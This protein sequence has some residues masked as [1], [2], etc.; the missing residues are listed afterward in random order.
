VLTEPEEVPNTE[1]GEAGAD[2]E[3]LMMEEE[4]DDPDAS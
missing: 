4:I 2:D 3:K 1:S